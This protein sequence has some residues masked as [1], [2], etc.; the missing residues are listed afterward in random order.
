MATQAVTP[1]L[2]D[3]A[4]RELAAALAA[5]HR[6][7]GLVVRGAD[8][9]GRIG[10]RLLHPF[11][12]AASHP[13]LTS[14]AETAL[15]RAY[16]VAILGLNAPAAQ[17]GAG[18]RL[19]AASGF[20]GGFAGPVGFVPD[21]LF[22]TLMIM[23][24]VARAA[25]DA[26]EDLATESARAACIHVFSLRE[27]DEAGYLSARFALQ[28]TAARTLLAGVAARWGMVLG[29]KFAAGAVPLLG[30]A[31]GAA[32]N[33][34]FLAH[35]RRLARAHFAIRRLERQ[36]GHA[37]IQAAAPEL[38]PVEDARFFEN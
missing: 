10:A 2:D 33:T 28:G 16:D 36:F 18:M 22:T 29:E 1:A 15:E 37:A 34:A 35:Y 3:A 6:R 19:V 14:I 9:L 38:R 11:G 26:G 13:I 21:A 20:A 4:R 30:G 27:G 12:N 7:D 31:A 17:G 23:R 5:L 32:L 25:R 24:E 8:L